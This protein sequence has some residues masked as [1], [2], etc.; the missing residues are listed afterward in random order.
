MKNTPERSRPSCVNIFIVLIILLSLFPVT[1]VEWRPDLLL[2]TTDNSLYVLER[3]VGFE[4][5]LASNSTRKKNKDAPLL[6]ELKRQFKS[7]HFVN[8]VI[9]A[10]GIFSNSCT[11]FREMCNSLS[12]EPQHKRFLISKLSILAIRTTYYIFPIRPAQFYRFN[13]HLIW[14]SIYFVIFPIVLVLCCTLKPGKPIS[15]YL[16]IREACNCSFNWIW[17][18]G[19]HYYYLVI[20]KH[21]YM[22]NIPEKPKIY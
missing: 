20:Q 9:S 13:I 5:N 8:L 22:L 18:K 12:I 10:L 15:N 17:M 1:G 19:F 6:T 21:C 3:T 14:I 7:V 16:C 4:T 2:K 11:S